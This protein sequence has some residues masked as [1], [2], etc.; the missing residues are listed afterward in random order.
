[1]RLL[2]TLVSLLNPALLAQHFDLIANALLTVAEDST[3]LVAVYVVRAFVTFF[4]RTGLNWSATIRKKIDMPRSLLE[5]L[6][7]LS[8]NSFFSKQVK[9]DSL[10]LTLLQA[11]RSL[12]NQSKD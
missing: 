4:K 9:L 8:K 10:R 2:E 11:L 5:L 3:R 6:D 1:M 12:F 7:W